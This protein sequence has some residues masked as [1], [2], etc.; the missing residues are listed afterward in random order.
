MCI[1]MNYEM[2]I[3]IYVPMEHRNRRLNKT[4]KSLVTPVCCKSNNF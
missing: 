1:R 3:F 4:S 2:F